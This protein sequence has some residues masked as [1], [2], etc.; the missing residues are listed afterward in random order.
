MM[1]KVT[2]FC[3]S[4]DSKMTQGNTVEEAY[5]TMVAKVG[6]VDFNTCQFYRASPV[7]VNLVV[8]GA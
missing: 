8:E 2:Y 7:A 1:N 3:I 5:Q 4:I 6:A